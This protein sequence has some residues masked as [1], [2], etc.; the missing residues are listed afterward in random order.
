MKKHVNMVVFERTISEGC[1][2]VSMP[3]LH[4]LGLASASLILDFFVVSDITA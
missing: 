2:S 1:K 3:L 4:G